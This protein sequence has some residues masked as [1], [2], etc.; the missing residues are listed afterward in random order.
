MIKKILLVFLF[1]LLWAGVA[2]ATF[3]LSSLPNLITNPGFETA[4]GSEWDLYTETNNDTNGG[5]GDSGQSS[6]QAYSGTKSYKLNMKHT[7]GGGSEALTNGDFETGAVSPWTSNTGTTRTIVTTPVHGGTYAMRISRASTGTAQLKQDNLTNLTGGASYTGRAWVQWTNAGTT[8]LKVYDNTDTIEVCSYVYSGSVGTYYEGTCGFTATTGHNYLLYVQRTGLA[9]GQYIYVDD[10]SLLPAGT[11]VYDSVEQNVTGLNSSKT[12]TAKVRVRDNSTVG[13]STLVVSTAQYGGGTVLCSSADTASNQGVFTE[14]T[15][16]AAS[17][18]TAVYWS[19]TTTTSS[20]DNTDYAYVDAAVLEQGNGTDILLTV[21]SGSTGRRVS[22]YNNAGTEAYNA[23]SGSTSA[24][25]SG[26]ANGSYF[27]RI[28]DID[29]AAFFDNSDY[30]T[31]TQGDTWDWANASLAKDATWD[32]IITGDNNLDGDCTDAGESGCGIKLQRAGAD[33]AYFGNNFGTNLALSKTITASTG[34]NPGNTNDGTLPTYWQAS[35]NADQWLCLDLG[36]AQAVNTAS[37]ISNYTLAGRMAS[38]KIQTHP[39]DQSCGSGEAWADVTGSSMTTYKRQQVSITSFPSQTKRYVRFFISTGSASQPVVNELALH[40][41]S[42]SNNPSATMSFELTNDA[43]GNFYA[44]AGFAYDSYSTQGDGSKTLVK[45]VSGLFSLS[46]NVKKF[47]DVIRARHTVSATADA[48]MS[49]KSS[50][51]RYQTANCYSVNSD[52][53]DGAA[54]ATCA[55]F[56]NDGSDLRKG[57]QG[58]GVSF[59]YTFGVVPD[60]GCRSKWINHKGG[61]SWQSDAGT[62]NRELTGMLA[63]ENWTSV[64]TTNSKEWSDGYPDFKLKAGQSYEFD[65]AYFRSTDPRPY[66]TQK[67]MTVALASAKE[68]NLNA[69]EKSLWSE[70]YQDYMKF[71]TDP[72]YCFTARSIM[73]SVRGQYPWEGLFTVIG[74]DDADIGRQVLWD[75][76]KAAFDVPMN[77]TQGRSEVY[78]KDALS[79]SPP[80]LTG[81]KRSWIIMSI[82]LG[83]SVRKGWVTIQPTCGSSDK[84]CVTESERDA[85]YTA[86][87]NAIASNGETYVSGPDNAQSWIIGTLDGRFSQAGRGL[88][89]HPWITGTRLVAYKAA[90]NYG[91]TID[92]TKLTNLKN[93]YTGAYDS[94]D[95]YVHPAKYGIWRPVSDGGAGGGQYYEGY[96]D[97]VTLYSVSTARFVIPSGHTN[98]ALTIHYRTDVDYGMMLVKKNGVAV[99][100][101]GF[102]NGKLDLYSATPAFTSATTTETVSTGD[103]IT[104]QVVSPDEKNASSTGYAIS[105]DKLVVGATTYEENDAGGGFQCGTTGNDCLNGYTRGWWKRGKAPGILLWEF[106]YR[107]MF[108]EKLLTDAQ[109]RSHIE[110]MVSGNQGHGTFRGPLQTYQDRLIP[111]NDT[112]CGG[113]CPAFNYTDYVG[114]SCSNGFPATYANG[115][116]FFFLD[117]MMWR[118]A[119][120][121]MTDNTV[122]L[123]YRWDDKSDVFVTTGAAWTSETDA[124]NY[125]LKYVEKATTAGGSFIEFKNVAL[126]D[127]QVNMVTGAGQGSVKIYYNDGTGYDAGTTVDLSTASNPVYSKSNVGAQCNGGACKLKFEWASGGAVRLDYVRAKSS[128]SYMLSQRLSEEYYVEPHTNEWLVTDY[129]TTDYRYIAT[130]ESQATHEPYNIFYRGQGLTALQGGDGINP[131]INHGINRL[132]FG[133]G[134]YYDCDKG[135]YS[136]RFQFAPLQ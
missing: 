1:A 23:V 64:Y 127:A 83:H 46:T 53:A 59:P 113:G 99:T 28:T 26:V 32:F 9:S 87:N 94:T 50:L 41:E 91:S 4:P 36:S 128:P 68:K 8:T 88:D 92:Q 44:A 95:G 136:C 11:T 133:G 105:F 49:M 37:I 82:L 116:S 27:W 20:A 114:D 131:G 126:S 121:F 62:P 58:T 110:N 119:S 51:V 6:E 80:A 31:V 73:Y 81:G 15:C 66:A 123:W 75:W 108:N 96:A 7:S 104:L 106:L 60:A 86:M 102:T 25:L 33:Y 125:Y 112:V 12:S 52:K 77:T 29:G 16:N 10:T 40:N 129:N 111:N 132:I 55:S 3:N 14:L 24:L 93:N 72:D 70:A 97:P 71:F 13:Y 74:L 54:V 76:R 38:L 117:M 65:V 85:L 130:C 89:L 79:T 45:N 5:A 135:L 101:T 107:I 34:A 61:T 48:S 78:P 17:G 30:V 122:G 98:A 42:A 18:Y 134:T 103:V 109:V 84:A 57:F 120:A 39:L 35:T 118:L 2:E 124:N 47:T 90:E 22:L 19:V 100:G 69:D 21:P 67:S 43:G 115:G 63:E 56:T